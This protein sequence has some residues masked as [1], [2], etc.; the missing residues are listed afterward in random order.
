[1]YIRVQHLRIAGGKIIEA[2][3]LVAFTSKLVGKMG[4]EETGSTGDEE[5]HRWIILLPK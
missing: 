3:H 4:T 5:I 2:T 1:M